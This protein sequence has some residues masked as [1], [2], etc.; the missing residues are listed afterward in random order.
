MSD[1]EQTELEKK[2]SEWDLGKQKK[3]PGQEV[4]ITGINIP[5]GQLVS[6]MVV[7]GIAAIPAG[8][9]LAIFWSVVISFIPSLARIL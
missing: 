4:T 1:L 2:Q 3:T 8:I 5:F 6:F 7:V 9:I